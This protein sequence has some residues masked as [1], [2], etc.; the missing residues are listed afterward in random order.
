MHNRINRLSV[1]TEISFYVGL[2]HWK[3][4]NNIGKSYTLTITSSCG[5][6]VESI[7]SLTVLLAFEISRAIGLPILY[8]SNLFLSLE[9]DAETSKHNIIAEYVHFI[10]WKAPK[11]VQIAR[12]GGRTGYI[13]REIGEV[14][15]FPIVFIRTRCTIIDGNF[16]RRVISRFFTYSESFSTG[17]I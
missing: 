14:D 6:N 1:Q 17:C 3:I 16:Q 10:P 12:F 8:S 7:L 15:N 5:M 9:I 4:I 2:K 11:L 13:A